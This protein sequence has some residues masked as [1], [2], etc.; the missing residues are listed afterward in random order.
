MDEL[1]WIT[2]WAAG[3]DRV[4]SIAVSS[5]VFYLIVVL[6]VRLMGK[7][8]TAQMNSFDW[9][10]T[11]A[12]GSLVA[13]GILLEDVAITD[14]TTAIAALALCQWVMTWMAM[15]SAKFSNFVKPVP[16]LLVHKGEYLESAM[17]AERITKSEVNV[18]LRKKGF[19]DVR[20]ANWVILETNGEMTVVPRQSTK[21]REAGLMDEVYSDVDPSAVSG[22]DKTDG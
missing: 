8:V 1:E 17:H 16:R 4:I 10:I 14:A 22:Q 13:S 11:V 6:L 15:K 9:I 20:D 12:V 18:A 3:W 19:T 5:V 21:F 7:R 2:N